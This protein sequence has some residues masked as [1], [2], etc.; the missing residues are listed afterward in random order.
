MHK[1]H[2]PNGRFGVSLKK[3]FRIRQPDLVGIIFGAP[4]KRVLLGKRKK[5]LIERIYSYEKN[6]EKE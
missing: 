4:T 3:C 6:K 5:Q 2:Q 1:F